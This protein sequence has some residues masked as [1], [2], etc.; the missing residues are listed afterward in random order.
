MLKKSF[1][2]AIPL[3]ATVAAALMFGAAAHAQY[4][5]APVGNAPSGIAGTTKPQDAIVNP[6][7]T[8][9]SGMDADARSQA[10]ADKKA[11]KDAKRA[12]RR[13]RTKNNGARQD[14]SPEKEI[15]RITGAA[16]R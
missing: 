1:M 13:N 15:E 9:G 12:A 3:A 4:G 10:R 11:K 8:A 14:L 7:P 6:A 5:S 2:K 16:P